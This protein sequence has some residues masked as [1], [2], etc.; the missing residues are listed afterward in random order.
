[1]ARIAKGTAALLLTSLVV[2]APST[3]TA[4][5]TNQ[6]GG[7]AVISGWNEIAQKTFLADT[8]KAVP[9]DFLYMGLVQAA[10]Y[11]RRSRHRGSLP[12]V[13]LFQQ[14]TARSLLPGGRGSCRPQGS[15]GV[16]A[17]CAARRPGYRVRRISGE[18][19]GR[20]RRDSRRRRSGC[21]RPTP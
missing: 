6:V 20:R 7:A 3:A 16:F 11:E 21:L 18:N 8:D 12:A 14:G 5:D 2:V 15:V 1:M 10:V 17:G 4:K 13:S 9:E 19:P